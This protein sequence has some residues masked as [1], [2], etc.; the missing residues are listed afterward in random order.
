MFRALCFDLFD[1]LVDLSFDGLPRMRIAGRERPTTAGLLHDLIPAEKD[2]S[3]EAFAEALATVDR[4]NRAIQNREGVEVSTRSRFD[5]LLADL[6]WR[7]P[8]LAQQLADRHMELFRQQVTVPGHHRAVLE[9]LAERYP[10]LLCSN[11]TDTAAALR[12]LEDAGFAPLFRHVVVS[13]E[14]GFRKPRPE[15][16]D[17]VLARSGLAAEDVLH[18]GDNLVADVSGAKAKGMPAV[19]LTRRV[20]EPEKVRGAYRGVA[21]D[22]VISDLSQLEQCL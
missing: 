21:P 8:E 14:V 20:A 17:A 13:E 15:I 9:E 18:V 6:G 2:V 19:W 10:L 3:Q 11:F 7:D 5:A 16:F 12:V 4:K 1:T 22:F